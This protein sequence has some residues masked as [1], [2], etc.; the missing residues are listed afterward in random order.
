LAICQTPLRC[1]VSICGCSLMSM[2]V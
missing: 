1:T 2:C